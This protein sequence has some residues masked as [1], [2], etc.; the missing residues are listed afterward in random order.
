MRNFYVL[1]PYVVGGSKKSKSLALL[2][3]AR[4]VRECNISTS[5]VFALKADQCTKTITVQQTLYPINI[6]KEMTSPTGESLDPTDQQAAR[7]Q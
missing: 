4:M 2:I 3:P 6:E 5:T 7:V 1:Q